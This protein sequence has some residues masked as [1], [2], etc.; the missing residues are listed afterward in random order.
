MERS[1]YQTRTGKDAVYIKSVGRKFRAYIV[2]LP[3]STTPMNPPTVERS[4]VV[5]DSSG[6][7]ISTNTVDEMK[8]QLAKL[9][10]LEAE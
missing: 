7:I 4:E 8:T 9:V 1:G 3:M 6:Q 10:F 2:W 5:R